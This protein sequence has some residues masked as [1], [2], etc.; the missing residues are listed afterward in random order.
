MPYIFTE[1]IVT[2][3]V[4]KVTKSEKSQDPGD[5]NYSADFCV[6]DANTRLICCVCYMYSYTYMVASDNSG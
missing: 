5:V 3:H 2:K 6:V 4:L 1:T